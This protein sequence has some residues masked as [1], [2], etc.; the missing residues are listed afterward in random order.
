MISPEDTLRL[1][2]LIA[3]CYAIRIDEYKMCVFGLD[4]NKKEHKM[5]FNPNGDNTQ[6]LAEIRRFLSAKVLGKMGG[7]P[8]YLKRW[9]RLGDVSLKNLQD[10]LKLG[11]VEAVIAVA[12]NKH[13][14]VDILP[15][16]WWCATNTDEQAE[17]GRFLLAK[18]VVLSHPIKSDISQFL[19]EFLPFMTEDINALMNT[20]YL[21]L[22]EDLVAEEI[23]EKLWQQGQGKVYFLVPFL[24]CRAGK[25]PTVGTQFLPQEQGIHG[26]EK[27][28]TKQGQ[29][30]LQTSALILKKINHEYVLYRAL[31]ALGQYCQHPMVKSHASI[32]ALELEVEQVMAKLNPPN[33]QEK[34]YARLLLAGVSERLVVSE[35]ARHALAGSA[36]RKKLV[37]IFTPIQKALTVLTHG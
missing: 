14:P 31:E 33:H 34:I 29:L 2:S 4:K 17:I 36:I 19:L 9:S 24:E 25:L 6:Y 7:Y 16:V 28:S 13:L 12:N 10:L 5:T 37:A 35:I 18:N 32:K 8:T 11:D 1:N 21:L 20:V 23:V 22:Q 3:L 26:L 30:F 27:I 15:L